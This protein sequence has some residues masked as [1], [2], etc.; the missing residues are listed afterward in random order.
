MKVYTGAVLL[1]FTV[2]LASAALPPQGPAGVVPPGD[3]YEV[4][5]WPTAAGAPQVFEHSQEAGPDETLFLVGT[6]LTDQ[7][8]VWGHHPDSPGG[9]AVPVKVQLAT[10]GYLA[11]T[12]PDSAY[13]GPMVVAVKNAAGTSEPIVINAPQP[14]WCAPQ[15]AAPGARVRVFG[16][17]L[18]CRPDGG[19]AVVWLAVAG[20]N[21]RRIELSVRADTKSRLRCLT[22]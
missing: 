1:S 10:N 7:V 9:R 21:G 16:R 2:L 22:T 12:V 3:A 17:N 5:A 15:A 19:A 11:F 14:W 13:D 4:P 18:A 6:N 8:L 20:Q